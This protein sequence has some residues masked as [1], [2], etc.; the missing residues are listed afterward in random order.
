[1]FL[2][3]SHVICVLACMLI[4]RVLDYA[5][6]YVDSSCK[7]TDIR[8]SK[9]APVKAS[10]SVW[11]RGPNHTVRTCVFRN[12]YYR[13]DTGD[14]VFFHGPGTTLLGDLNGRND[15]ALT[16]LSSVSD[17]GAFYFN[18][19]DLPLSAFSEL[20]VVDVDSDTLVVSRF[21]PDNLMHVFHDDLIP[22]FSTVREIRSCS[23]SVEV[24][25]CLD[26]ITLFLADERRKGPYWQLYKA[27]IKNG[28]ILHR[29]QMSKWHRFRRA[30]VGLRKDSTW[31][32]YG[33]VAPQGP[34]NSN[35]K[36]AGAEVG[37][38]AQ[39]FLHMLDV[40]LKSEM[41]RSLALII[42]R[43][44]NRRITNLG[45]LVNI[46]KLHTKLTTVVINLESEAL[47]DVVTLLRRTQLLISM[48]G[49]AL[50]LSMFL[51]PGSAVLEL[52]PYGINPDNY[53]PYKILANLP[54]MNIAYAAWRNTNKTNTVF[55]PEFEPQYGGIYHL[56][57]ET[58]QQIL[59]SKE[60][61]P[62]LCCDNPNWLFHIYQDTA[63]DTSIVPMLI[64]LSIERAL[65]RNNH[66]KNIFPGQVLKLKC[67]VHKY[68]EGNTQLVVSWLEPWNVALA[69]FRHC[70]YEA[71]LKNG[72]QVQMIH[73]NTT[74]FVQNITASHLHIWVKA[75][76]D[77]NSGGFNAFPPSCRDIAY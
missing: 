21:N 55:H 69:S 26:N 22:I 7:Q 11:C 36:T 16:D 30:I 25:H 14:F 35:L 72:A 68:S 37:L 2:R 56:P 52:F 28:K 59:L 6:Q 29:T 77:G 58:Q 44:K 57:L 8:H 64:N 48:H 46:V 18:F 4:D 5:S 20:D 66:N 76:C 65:T 13:G 74:A 70:Y 17:H 31:Y 60:V 27:L 43:T 75:V 71:W 49:S 39:F 67:E 61:P 3:P 53:T 38:F 1:M 50:I 10:S 63:V 47:Q 9:G 34:L 23:S 19:V 33:F 12:L 45:E 62:H 40:P 73:T 54:P 15:P 51:Q 24:L 32:Q 42:S 41:N